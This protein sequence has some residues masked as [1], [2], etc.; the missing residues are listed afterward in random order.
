MDTHLNISACVAAQQGGSHQDMLCLSVITVVHCVFLLL[1]F[2][3]LIFQQQKTHTAFQNIII[4]RVEAKYLANSIFY[5]SIREKL[6]RYRLN[7]FQDILRVLIIFANLRKGTV[8]SRYIVSFNISSST[9]ARCAVTASGR[10][11][12][13]FANAPR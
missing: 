11:H 7:S 3:N 12:T 8:N 2:F 5:Y 9:A 13:Y 6:L 1:Q 10:K 4:M